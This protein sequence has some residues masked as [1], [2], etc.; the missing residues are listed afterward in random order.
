MGLPVYTGAGKAGTAQK[1]VSYIAGV[2]LNMLIPPAHLREPK[3][4][5]H[6]RHLH[7]VTIAQ[8]KGYYP[9]RRTVKDT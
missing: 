2:S 4:R 7:S 5:K 9:A 6:S 3:P 8:Q 1:S